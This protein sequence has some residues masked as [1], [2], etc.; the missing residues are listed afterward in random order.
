MRIAILGSLEVQSGGHRVELSGARLQALLAR[1]A[2]DAGR[3]VTVTSLADAIWDGDPPR[4][5]NHALQ[6]LVSRLRRALD[7]GDAIQPSGDGYRL[8]IDPDDVDAGRFERLAAEGSVLLRDGDAGRARERLGEALALWR[9]TPLTGLTSPAFASTIAR[10]TDA[11]VAAVCDRVEAEF[12]LGH[13]AETVGELEALAAEHPL[14]ERLI[15]HLI[16]ALYAAGRQADALAAYE[17]VRLRLSEELGVAPSPELQKAHLAV[18]TGTPPPATAPASSPALG[19]G[20]SPV[21]ARLTSFVG[22]ESEL[23]RVAELLSD[24]RLVTLIGAGGAGKTRLA[25]EL[26]DGWSARGR[27]AAWMAELAPVGDAAGIGPALLTAIGVR[28]TQ[29]LSSGKAPVAGDAIAHVSEVVADRRALLVLDNCEH[30]IGAVAEL[31]ER[32]LGGCARLRILTTTREPL[33]ITGETIVPVAPLALPDREMSAVE[34]LQVPAVRL[35]ADRAAAASAGFTVDETTVGDVVEICRRVDGQPLALELAA[36]RLRSMTLEQLAGRLDD[37]FRL[38]TGGSRTAMAR[39]RTLRAVVD[40]SWDLL[41]DAERRMLGRLAVFPGGATLEAA[42][43]VCA[44]G[45]VQEADVFDLVS[46]L[47]DKSLL[48][49]ATPAAGGAR[50]RM[51]ETIREY[52][53]ERA[54][55]AGELAAV[56]D[57]HARHYLALALEGDRHLRGPDQVG[58]QRR[59]NAEHDNLLAALRHL[60]E[61]GDARAACAMVVAMLWFWL[62]SGA[63][64]DEVLTW[65]EFARQMPGDADP[66]DRLMIETVHAM[67]EV[68]PGHQSEADPFTLMRQ[69]LDRISDADLSRHPLLAA[70]RPMLAVA[71]G[72]ERMLELLEHSESHP[73]PWVRAT[74]PFV[75]VQIFENE[76]D[77]DGLR[78]ALHESVAAF[79]EVGDRWG[80]GT[81][82]AEL[83]GLRILEGDLD[84]AEGALEQTR[85]LMAEMGGHS[86]NIMIGLR[87]ADLRSR[88]GDLEGARDMLG[89]ELDARE[90]YPEEQ[91]MLRITLSTLTLRTGDPARARD[92]AE[93]A[94]REIGPSRGTRPDQGHVRAMVLSGLAKVYLAA[95]ETERAAE[96]LAEAYEKAVATQDMPIVAMVGVTV[97][98]L[99]LARGRPEAAAGILGAGV[100]LRGAED[101]THIEIVALTAQ[102]RET[103]G[104]AGLDAAYDRGRALDRDAALRCLDPERLG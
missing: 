78:S 23:E 11:R 84:G 66:L 53:L 4:D 101:R 96:L 75:R 20:G 54:E 44:G 79:T 64:R 89:A 31:A 24:H 56:R 85:E 52:G 18:I 76:G 33:A 39:Q 87:L 10:L 35:F 65:T 12:V 6:S 48:Q 28:E 86:D 26:A 90:R 102:L 22:R 74:A 34:A 25:T 103:L 42:E 51:L 80:L 73:D 29:L 46:A 30:L 49:I 98:A 91:A 27:G 41:D 1:L 19:A 16:M 38:L 61:S 77:V 83:A 58:W 40:W 93:E 7:D 17:R 92:L 21:A 69:L 95:G 15:A 32:L 59:L 47:V 63:S 3:P 100:R 36:A 60:G 57:A 71:V 82:L 45:P 62:T 97:A 99:A 70:I 72:R 94:L 81:V 9:D 8:M 13:I 67:A 43:A 2:V 50:Y 37:R 104:E 68:L 14:H 55:E 5:E 88:R